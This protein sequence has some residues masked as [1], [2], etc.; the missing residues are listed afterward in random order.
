MGHN[1]LFFSATRKNAVPAAANVFIPVYCETFSTEGSFS[2]R[3]GA[4]F[5]G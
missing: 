3:S 1:T 2:M 5:A 4:I